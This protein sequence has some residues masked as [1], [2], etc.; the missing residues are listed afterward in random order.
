MIESFPRPGKPMMAA[1][2]AAFDG[3]ARP[4]P[5]DRSRFADQDLDITAGNCSGRGRT[6]LADVI[7]DRLATHP[8]GAGAGYCLV[9]GLA[10]LMSVEETRRFSAALFAEVWQRYRASCAR[11]SDDREFCEAET[12]TE[13]GAIPVEL[14][15]SRWSFKLP[16]ADRNGFLFAHVYGPG[17]GFTGGDVLV[18]DALAYVKELGLTFDDAMT[19]SEDLGVQKP[20]LRPDHV[21]SAVASHG[22]RLG[23]LTPD[24]ILL[25]NNGPDGLLH[26]ATDLDISD[27]RIFTRSL[28]RVVVRERDEQDGKW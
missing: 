6:A 17:A 21:E 23:R 10:A 18:I 19:W 4:K 11:I 25:V 14:F 1:R 2:R 15:G 8:D 9:G 28:H 24:C 5:F 12:L 13:D 16:H 7:V 27:E 22:R 26:G 20:V 3:R